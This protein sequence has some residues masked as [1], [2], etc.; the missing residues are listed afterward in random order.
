MPKGKKSLKRARSVEASPPLEQ[1]PPKTKY[2][3]IMEQV[4]VKKKP[5]TLVSLE[6]KVFPCEEAMLNSRELGLRGK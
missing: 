5:L 1:A 3:T 2:K 6:I 4:V